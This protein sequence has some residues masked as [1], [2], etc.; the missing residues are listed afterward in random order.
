MLKICGGL[1]LGQEPLGANHCC[2][3]RSQDFHCDFPVVLQILGKIYIG[4][5]AFTD[6]LLDAVAPG[7]GVIDASD[8]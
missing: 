4:H 3:L 8:S 1:Y 6:V 7:E 5:P 2:E